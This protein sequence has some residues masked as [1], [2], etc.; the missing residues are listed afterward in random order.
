MKK[1]DP[2]DM[3]RSC[4]AIGPEDGVDPKEALRQRAVRKPDRKAQQLCRQV[5]HAI[6]FALASELNCDAVRDLIV[7]SVSPAPASYH[8]LVILT[9][10][11]AVTEM[12]A[13][14][15]E[16]L[17][18]RFKGKIRWI[19]SASIHRKKTPDITLRVVNS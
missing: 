16:C 9:P 1:P 4:G 11:E 7:A 14:E 13:A 2:H 10:P 8:L 19:I 6:N 18:A 12:Q 3:L 5:E 15:L 17:L